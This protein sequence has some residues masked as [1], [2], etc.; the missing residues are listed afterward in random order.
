MLTQYL[1]EENGTI[2]FSGPVKNLEKLPAGIYAVSQDS[3]GALYLMEETTQTDGLIELPGSPAQMINKK[4]DDFLSER[5]R[6]AFD[7]YRMLYK[8]GILMF[9][10]PGTG[11]TSII[12]ILMETAIKKDMIVLLG[13]SPYWVSNVIYSIRQ[14]EGDDRPVMVVWEELERWIE[15][16][17]GSLLDLLDGTDQV[18]NVFYIATTNYIEDV[19]SRIRNRPSRFAEVLEIGPPDKELRRAFLSAKVH[20]ED[21]IDMDEWVEKTEGL[22]IDHLKDLIISVL[23]LD[24]PLD[25]AI[26]KLRVLEKDDDFYDEICDVPKSVRKRRKRRRNTAECD[27]KVA[28]L[29]EKLEDMGAVR[30]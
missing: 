15:D 17:E 3:F 11:K 10:P 6:K 12:H 27:S 5:I 22:T 24:L 14:I 21:N 28:E 1:K 8:R 2:R 13:P 26:E 18:D 16:C 4:V 30:P 23:V 29:Y 25:S 19:P 9:G 7:R 20:E